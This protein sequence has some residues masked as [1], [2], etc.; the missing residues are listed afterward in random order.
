[1]QTAILAFVL[2]LLGVVRAWG[3]FKLRNPVTWIYLASLAGLV[4]ALPAL[5]ITI[6]RRRTVAS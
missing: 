3:D 5:Y 1:V 6:E 2:I 4:V